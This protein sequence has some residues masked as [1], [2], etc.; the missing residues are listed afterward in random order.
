[1][2][3]RQR[4]VTKYLNPLEVDKQIKQL[5]A[6]FP[7]ICRLETL[8][9]LSHGYQ[10]QR[11]EARGRHKTRVLRITAP[12]LPPAPKPAVLFFRSTHAREW[13]NAMAA[14]ELASQLV[15]NYRPMDT[16]PRVRAIVQTLQKVEFL[17]IAESNPDGAR[18]SFFDPGQKMWRKNLRPP[19]AGQTCPGVDCNRNFSRYWGGGGSSSAPCSETYRG[20]H[21]M[22]EPENANIGF[23]AAR[24]RNLVFAIDAHSHGQA[25]FRP[26]PSGGQFISKMPVS[27]EDHAIYLHLEQAINKAIQTVQGAKYSTGT[28][29]NHAGTSDEYL[30]FEHHIFAICLECAQDFQPPV[31]DAI[32]AALEVT[33]AAK[34]MGWCAAGKTGLDIPALVN[35]RK[36]VP[37]DAFADSLM[38]T[39]DVTTPWQ[40]EQIPPQQWR[41]Y[42]LKCYP[43]KKKTL[44]PEYKKLMA[45]GIDARLDPKKGDFY[46]V[47]ASAEDLTTLLELGYQPIVQRDLLSEKVK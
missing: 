42:L 44:I 16:N 9:H 18:L 28:T 5:A 15:E 47:I 21:A 30:F 34:A 29:N 36:K 25:I 4:F 8:P 26:W 37:L 33:E 32:T 39:V 3:F 11:V 35:A 22:S 12:G 14:V 43:L 41:R 10:G 27:K 38:E 31:A 17:I 45:R 46:E 6:N 2:A 13:I 1:M 20:P 24:E 19:P 7:Q 40:V 23:L